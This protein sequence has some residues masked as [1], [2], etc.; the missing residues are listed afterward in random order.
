[1]A[2][3]AGGLLDRLVHAPINFID[4]L[5]AYHMRA[6]VAILYGLVVTI[7]VHALAHLLIASV[8]VGKTEGEF[9]IWMPDAW[10]AACFRRRSLIDECAALGMIRRSSMSSTITM[11]RPA[12]N[13]IFFSRSSTYFPIC[14][15]VS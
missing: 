10:F 9:E 8:A 6:L 4:W 3:G 11:D 7:V 2:A 1:M 15:P 14:R 13:I 12:A 5:L